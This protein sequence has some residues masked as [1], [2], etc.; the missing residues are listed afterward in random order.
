M[1]TRTKT[2]PYLRIK[3]L[4][5]H[6]PFCGTY[7]CHIR[8]NCMSPDKM[9]D[10]QPG[11][12]CSKFGWR[13]PPDKSLSI[14]PRAFSLKNGPTHFLREKTWGRGCF[15]WISITETNCVINWIVN[16][17]VDKAIHLLNN[18]DE[19]SEKDVSNND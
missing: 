13:Y 4:R 11:L 19:V 3:P 7:R 16:Y 2:T 15:Q 17:P 10:L 9:G 18:W 8:E 12:G 14:V 6:T 5:N 1:P